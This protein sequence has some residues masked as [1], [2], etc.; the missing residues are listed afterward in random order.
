MNKKIVTR[1]GGHQYCGL[2]S[3]GDDTIVISMN[4]FNKLPDQKTFQLGQLL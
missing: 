2:S 1:S 3:G 4:N